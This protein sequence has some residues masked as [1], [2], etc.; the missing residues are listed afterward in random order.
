MGLQVEL[1][2]AQTRGKKAVKCSISILGPSFSETYFSLSD[3]CC[4]YKGDRM[5]EIKPVMDTL[6]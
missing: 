2:Q 4:Q 3:W 6:G 1:Q 5:G